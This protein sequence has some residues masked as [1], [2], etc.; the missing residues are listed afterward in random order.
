MN[1]LMANCA[2]ICSCLWLRFLQHIAQFARVN[3]DGHGGA[4]SLTLQSKWH[5]HV[6][7]TVLIDR[8]YS[9]TAL[10]F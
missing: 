10:L 8:F 6:S 4:R 9:K 2:Q 5:K 7:E 3:W 1:Q